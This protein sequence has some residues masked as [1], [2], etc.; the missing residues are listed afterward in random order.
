MG[1]EVGNGV[2]VGRI[3]VWFPDSWPDEEAWVG[4]AVGVAKGTI[5][6]PRGRGSSK[7]ARGEVLGLWFWKV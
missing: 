2:K 4:W 1:V 6:K 3:L 5:S 7:V